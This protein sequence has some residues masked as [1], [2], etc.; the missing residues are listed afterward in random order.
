MGPETMTTLR[1]SWRG[2]ILLCSSRLVLSASEASCAARSGEL[3]LLNLEA[4]P[5]PVLY[6]VGETVGISAC[7]GTLTKAEA[8]HGISP[9]PAGHSPRFADATSRIPFRIVTLPNEQQ[10]EILEAVVVWTAF[11]GTMAY[12]PEEYHRWYFLY[13]ERH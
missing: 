7:A 5:V 8:A 1:A 3:S 2:P 4:S 12:R 6:S 9:I 13:Q 11:V 10:I